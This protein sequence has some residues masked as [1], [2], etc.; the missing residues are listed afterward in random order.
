MTV[1]SGSVWGKRGHEGD[2]SAVMEISAGG[3][4]EIEVVGE[5]HYQRE[6]RECVRAGFDYEE[7]ELKASVGFAVRLV[8]EPRNQ[9]DAN[10][11]AVSSI[12]G[13]TL[14]YLERELAADFAPTLDELGDAVR[15]QCPARAFGRR[16]DKK[17]PW[18]F[19][20]WLDLPDPDD[21]EV[22]L[23]DLSD[24]QVREMAQDGGLVRYRDD[25]SGALRRLPN[26][27][28]GPSNRY[29]AASGG[30][31][32]LIPVACPGCGSAQ[33]AVPGP[34][35]FRCRACARD[36]WWINCHRCH[37]TSNLLGPIAGSGAIEFRCQHCRAKNTI[38]KQ[39]LRAISAEIRRTEQL[40]AAQ[41]KEAKVAAKHSRVRHAEDR[42]AEAELLTTVVRETVARLGSVL[43]DSYSDFAFSPLKR[44][45]PELVFSAATPQQGADEPVLETFLPDEPKGL[46]ALKPGPNGSISS[47][48]K[49]PKRRFRPRTT[50]TLA[51]K[52][53]GL[54]TC[55]PNATPS[56]LRLPNATRWSR[57]STPRSMSWKPSSQRASQTRSSPTARPSSMRCPSPTRRSAPSHV[58][59]TRRNPT[60]W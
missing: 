45:A 16:D 53:N 58:W 4:F 1:H 9:H 37:K 2:G 22:A 12:A 5:S 36:V 44:S 7:S 52:P 55:G 51:R 40:Q 35:G 31:A 6:I 49:R 46:A 54:R 25:D 8:R 24:T 15:V 56:T 33:T 11:I 26:S 34:K 39:S 47:R 29:S 43:Q 38:N 41:E 27:Q 13:T 19:G 14:G 17:A 21:L 59:R 23:G 3:G 20:L 60:S 10:A 18:N 42:Q 32:A 28:D 30:A 48:F 50:S 57:A